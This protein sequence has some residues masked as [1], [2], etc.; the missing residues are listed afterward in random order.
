MNGVLQGSILCLVLL[1]INDGI[2]CPLSMFADDSKLSGAA[3][4]AGMK[5]RHL[6]GV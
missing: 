1:N 5:G 2:E 6:E 4:T 3:D